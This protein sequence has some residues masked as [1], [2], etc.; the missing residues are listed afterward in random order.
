MTAGHYR[1]CLWREPADDCFIHFFVAV[2]RT[3]Y[4]S[5]F[6]AKQ[7]QE[8]YVR[9]WRW[10]PPLPIAFGIRRSRSNRFRLRLA[11]GYN[12]PSLWPTITDHPNFLELWKSIGFQM[13][14]PWPAANKWRTERRI[15]LSLVL[16]IILILFVR[17]MAELRRRLRKTLLSSFFLPTQQKIGGWWRQLCMRMPSGRK[18]PHTA[19]P[20]PARKP[21]S[22]LSC[23]NNLNHCLVWM[24]ALFVPYLLLPPPLLVL[25][26]CRLRTCRLLYRRPRACN[27]SSEC[28]RSRQRASFS[29]FIFR[30]FTECCVNLNN[31]HSSDWRGH[32]FKLIVEFTDKLGNEMPKDSTYSTGR[33]VLCQVLADIRVTKN[34]GVKGL[35]TEV[36]KGG[37]EKR[38]QQS[39]YESKKRMRSNIVVASW[40]G[41]SSPGWSLSLGPVS[42]ST[43]WARQL[44]LTRRAQHTHTHTRTKM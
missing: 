10:M 5:H 2:T 44:P 11:A 17:Q 43:L 6:W 4:N 32:G 34:V 9:G 28:C 38:K 24:H 35:F 30:I 33:S 42:F 19:Q 3:V 31:A 15:A 22:L 14:V 16:W 25:P 20:R 29:L 8:A 27:P 1:C 39:V 18:K 41:V 37:N 13:I 26:R 21:S 36:E 40:R 7:R 12:R 23:T